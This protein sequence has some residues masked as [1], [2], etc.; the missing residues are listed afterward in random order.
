MSDDGLKNFTENLKIL[1][2]TFDLATL[3][4]PL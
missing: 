2:T 3:V 1:D 4:L